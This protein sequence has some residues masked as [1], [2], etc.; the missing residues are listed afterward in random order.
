MVKTAVGTG[1]QPPDPPY[2]VHAHAEAT[3]HAIRRIRRNRRRLTQA[4]AEI[5]VHEEANARA[6]K[7]PRHVARHLARFALRSFWWP[8]LHPKQAR[9]EGYHFVWQRD[10]E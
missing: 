10:P 8:L 2:D 7:V 4:D 6:V 9:Q 1:D 3:M 5:I